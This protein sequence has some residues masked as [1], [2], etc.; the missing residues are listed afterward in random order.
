MTGASLDRASIETDFG[1]SSLV[2]R[3]RTMAVA[4]VVSIVEVE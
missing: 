2:G 3:S 1:G 4:G